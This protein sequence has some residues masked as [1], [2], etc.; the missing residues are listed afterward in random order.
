MS[1]TQVTEAGNSNVMEILGFKKTLSDIE[2][3]GV[4]LKR[5]TTDR[6][7]QIRKY[8]REKRP[9]IPHQFDV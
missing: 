1:V 3:K 7:V 4:T 8:L 9:D 6:H 2:Y 5:L